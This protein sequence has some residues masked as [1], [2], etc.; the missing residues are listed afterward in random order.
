[1]FHKATSRDAPTTVATHAM[2][3]MATVQ[4]GVVLLAGSG[5]N[6]MPDHVS[7]MSIQ[8]RRSRPVSR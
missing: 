2:L 6:C 3:Q 5:T 7:F 4:V 8:V 1:M